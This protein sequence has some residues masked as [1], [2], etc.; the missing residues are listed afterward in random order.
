MQKSVLIGN[1]IN[2]A[3]SGNNDYKNYCIIQRLLDNLESGRFDE[4]FRSTVSEIELINL[5]HGLNDEFVK[6]QIG[7]QTLK[8]TKDEDEMMSFVDICKRYN[9]KSKGIL[10]V[11]IEDYFL[12]MKLFN[13]RFEED[14]IPFNVLSDGLKWLFLDAIFNE[15]KIEELYLNMESFKSEL[16]QFTSIFTVNYDSNL[17]KLLNKEV[18][19]LHG[20]FACLDDTYKENTLFGYLAKNN[21]RNNEI[22]TGMEHIY[23]NAVMGHSGRY[24]I[25]IME[26]YSNFNNAIDT[27]YRALTEVKDIEYI[28][29]Y[30]SLKKSNSEEDKFVVNAVEAKL[31]FPELKVNEYPLH[32]F[33]SI[34]GELYIIGMSANNDSHIFDAI[35]KNPNVSRVIYYSACMEDTLGAQH[36]ISKPIQF[37]D[38]HKYWKKIGI[39][40]K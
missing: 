30:E 20:S 37:R 35:N 28:S 19:H 11:G 10:E 12:V 32:E 26:K 3:F 33:K 39:N 13:N 14:I 5:I 6:M 23:C 22:I 36:A 40:N 4:V 7:L 38:V 1:G 31:K 15:G 17:D 25:S 8:W 27:M 16:E 29:K 24:K 2:I 18:V 21:L 34:K 9:G